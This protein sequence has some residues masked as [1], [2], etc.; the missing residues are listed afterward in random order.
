MIRNSSVRLRQ[1]ASRCWPPFA[2][3][4]N[5]IRTQL[6]QWT[7]AMLAIYA[8][9]A[10]DRRIT[11]LD[12]GVVQLPLRLTLVEVNGLKRLPARCSRNVLDIGIVRNLIERLCCSRGALRV[13]PLSAHGWPSAAPPSTC[14]RMRSHVQCVSIFMLH[15]AYFPWTVWPLLQYAHFQR[16]RSLRAP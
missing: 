11:H 9:N 16:C 7:R 8:A 13:P 14:F 5:T 1:H 10:L 4:I 6:K 2:A 3:N 12:H 15:R